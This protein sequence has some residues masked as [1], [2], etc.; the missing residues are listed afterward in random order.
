M[1]ALC[2]SNKLKGLLYAS[3]VPVNI[4]SKDFYM[5]ALCQSN[6][7]KGTLYASV[8]PVK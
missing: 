8:V 7:L 4:S 2:Q 6:K 3:I 1:Q 5:Q